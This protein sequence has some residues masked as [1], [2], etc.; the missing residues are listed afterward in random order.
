MSCRIPKCRRS[1]WARPA[2]SASTEP[3]PM[4]E[5]R[6][7]SGGWGPTLVVEDVDLRVDRGETVA[8][9]GRNG[10]G[11]STLLELIVGR[12]QRRGGSLLLED[13][14]IGTLATHE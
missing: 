6:K 7:L 11:K 4:L 9:V 3:W 2:R 12:A 10:V 13:G 8:V 14:D 1:T 5:L